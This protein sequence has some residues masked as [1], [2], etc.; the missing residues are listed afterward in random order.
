MFRRLP[1]VAAFAAFAALAVTGHSWATAKDVLVIDK[2]EDPP[3]ADPGVEVSNN[4]YTLIF[5]AYER[6]VKYDGAKTEVI[7]ELAD[8]WTV[9]PDNLSW[10]FKL[11]SGHMFDD[12]SPVDAAAVKYSFA[13]RNWQPALATCFQP[14]RTSS[15][16]IRRR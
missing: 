7:P 13:S 12:G 16:S 10:T 15:S 2:A 8:S 1:T 3:T 11:A 5:P 14:S 9:A 4:G 6:L